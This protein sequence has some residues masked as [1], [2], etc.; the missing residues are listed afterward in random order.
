MSEDT[1]DRE[2]IEKQKKDLA[3]FGVEPGWEKM[4]EAADKAQ[5]KAKQDPGWTEGH[6]EHVDVPE[7]ERL[8]RPVGTETINY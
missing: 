6:E 8:Q 7:D 1:I 3:G 2:N 5:Q 4:E